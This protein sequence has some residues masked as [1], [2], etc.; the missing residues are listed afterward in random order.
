MK[1]YRHKTQNYKLS[2]VLVSSHHG[3]PLLVIQEKN[4]N[5]LKVHQE[6]KLNVGL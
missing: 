6:M 1:Q 5:L 3:I 4:L 2:A